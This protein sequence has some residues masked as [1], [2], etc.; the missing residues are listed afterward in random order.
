MPG[1]VESPTDVYA[2]LGSP[3]A[4]RM[5]TT[6]PSSSPT[7]NDRPIRPALTPTAA[8]PQATAIAMNRRTPCRTPQ[9]I[10]VEPLPE[11]Q[12]RPDDGED[13]RED[14]DRDRDADIGGDLLDLA[15]GRRSRPSPGRCGPVRGGRPNLGSTGW[16]RADRVVAAV[17]AAE[18]V[19]PGCTPARGWGGHA[20]NRAGPGCPRCGWHPTVEPRP[21]DL[22][23]PLRCGHALEEPDP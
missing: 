16:R 3:K 15:G 23:A 5:P 7:R 11:E 4:M 10:D 6:S 19:R 20:R 13:D 14:D 12:R 17:A 2:Q 9:P 8:S 21:R 1:R 18:E 22:R